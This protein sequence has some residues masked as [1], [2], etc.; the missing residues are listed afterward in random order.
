MI[1]KTFLNQ[2]R[3][4]RP[5]AELTQSKKQ[6]DDALLKVTEIANN[7]AL[8]GSAK[9]SILAIEL[10]TI[11][12]RFHDGMVNSGLASGNEI[13]VGEV[14]NVVEDKLNEARKQATDKANEFLRQGRADVGQS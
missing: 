10:N 5:A 6:A 9:A 13:R 12:I 7:A 2:L 14:R 4:L 3:F 1:E 11:H 8:V